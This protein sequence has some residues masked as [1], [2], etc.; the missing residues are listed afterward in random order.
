MSSLRATSGERD[1]VRAVRAASLCECSACRTHGPDCSE[2]ERGCACRYV[3]DRSAQ[4]EA[5]ASSSARV[6][7]RAMVAPHACTHA[8]YN[9]LVP[10]VVHGQM[11]RAPRIPQRAVVQGTCV[12]VCVVRARP[13][14]RRLYRGDRGRVGVASSDEA[15]EGIAAA[16]GRGWPSP[17]C[18]ANDEGD[19]GAR[20]SATKVGGS[21]P[22]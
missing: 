4:G 5:L 3:A 7:P 2:T 16:A 18:P 22:I 20:R 1:S 15:F 17:R 19:R 14:V 12:A 13:Y 8:T 10:V 11:R 6:P 21:N 9:V